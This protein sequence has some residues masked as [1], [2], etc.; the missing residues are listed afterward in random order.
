MK[1]LTP[2]QRIDEEASLWATRIDGGDLN[3]NDQAAF[4]AWLKANPEHQRAFDK[5]R[6]LS[7]RIDTHIEARLGAAVETIVREQKTSRLRPRVFASALAAAAAIAVVLTALS[8]RP[9]SLATK[10]AERH[11][12]MLDDG[13]KVDL[14]ARTELSISFTHNERRVQLVSGEALF[15]VA[16]DARRPF[17]VQT[18]TGSVRV[19]GTVFNV[20]AANTERVEVTVLE[21]TVRVRP[22]GA[23]TNE[24][25]VTSGLQAVLSE[26]AVTIHALPDGTAQD[27]I[28]WRQGQVVFN[29]TPLGEAI[30]RFAAYHARAIIVDTKAANLRLGGRYSLEDLNGL[31]ESIESVLPVLV[32]HQPGGD[33]RITATEPSAKL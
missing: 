3:A 2:F 10:T 11:V 33:V 24:Q 21:G 26:N 6:E 8:G 31:L 5:Y 28:A 14:N 18:P 32:T 20:R 12:T 15:T 9:L 29:D 27:V 16:K 25:P 7:A 13:T 17:L 1:P 4:S 19:T 30:E 23:V 22:T